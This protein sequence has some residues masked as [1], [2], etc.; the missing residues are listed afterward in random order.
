[1]APKSTKPRDPKGRSLSEVK[2][3]LRAL[4]NRPGKEADAIA[5]IEE[6]VTGFGGMGVGAGGI[7][8]DRGAAILL[9]ANLESSLQI[10]IE[11]KEPTANRTATFERKIRKGYA[12]GLFGDETKN[13]LDLIRWIRNAF[14]HSPSPVRFSTAE[15]E[16]A[17]ALLKLPAPVGKADDQGEAT[18]RHRFRLACERTG[19]ALRY[20]PRKATALSSK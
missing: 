20:V 11:R 7:R 9:A 19:I 18:G 12:L 16:S 14:A 8:N 3:A 13:N 4:I 2:N 1:M 17:C 5:Y 6:V 10:A 15:I